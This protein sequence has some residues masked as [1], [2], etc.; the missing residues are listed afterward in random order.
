MNDLTQTSKILTMLRKAKNRGVENYRFSQQR[1]LRY[2]ARIKDLRDDGHNIITE[3]V[4]LN[5]RSTGVFRYT[6]I[7]NH[8]KI[9]W[10]YKQKIKKLYQEGF[11]VD[12]LCLM[13][14]LRPIDVKSTVKGIKR[15]ERV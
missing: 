12:E 9:N 2:S 11:S 1:I 3:R 13:Y 8:Q 5:G 4:K 7:E 15:V 6:L 14:N 10:Y